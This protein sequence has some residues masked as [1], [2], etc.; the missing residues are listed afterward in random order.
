MNRFRLSRCRRSGQLS[1]ERRGAARRHAG[2]RERA[3]Y[4]RGFVP[5]REPVARRYR[6]K[7]RRRQAPVGK[8]RRSGARRPRAPGRPSTPDRRRRRRHRMLRFG[9]PPR[10]S[11]AMFAARRRASA[12]SLA[13]VSISPASPAFAPRRRTNPRATSAP[14]GGGNL[15]PAGPRSRP[16]YPLPRRRRRPFRASRQYRSER[17]GKMI[18]ALNGAQSTYN[19]LVQTT[20]IGETR[21]VIRG[22]VSLDAIRE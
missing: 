3:L 6:G 10:R 19:T 2:V 17:V 22:A 4:R 7:L 18:G 16:N 5:G 9:A 13:G 20:I 1:P 14:F 12:L 11:P 8:C 15:A 21:V